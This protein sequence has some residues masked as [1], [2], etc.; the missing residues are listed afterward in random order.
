M[1]CCSP[2]M[3]LL[4]LGGW[5]VEG[6]CR[7]ETTELGKG[8]NQ[9]QIKTK[10]KTNQNAEVRE[11]HLP[12]LIIERLSL[13]KL[14]FPAS[15]TPSGTPSASVS[16]FQSKEYQRRLELFF[17]RLYVG[18][19][20]GH[21]YPT[22]Q[23]SFTAFFLIFLILNECHQYNN[24]S[25]IT[26]HLG[27][28]VKKW[29]CDMSAHWRYLWNYV[30]SADEVCFFPFSPTFAGL[31]IWQCQVGSGW[32]FLVQQFP[33]VPTPDPH[34]S[35]EHSK[36]LVSPC[37]YSPVTDWGWILG[38]DLIFTVFSYCFL[39]GM[40]KRNLVWGISKVSHVC[41]NRSAEHIR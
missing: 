7:W 13:E 33:F 35:S 16:L 39:K 26:I 27:T 8:S 6:A 23:P 18:D 20:Q 31:S 3:V 15:H 24:K 10:G 32:Q 38:R 19:L 21:V 37:L 4:W 9:G 17:P 5:G 34:G 29:L 12:L 2:G 36:P 30:L 22:F 11:I 40:W 1:T 14:L 41:I 28:A 25:N